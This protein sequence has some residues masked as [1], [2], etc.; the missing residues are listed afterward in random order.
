MGREEEEEKM[1]TNVVYITLITVE[2]TTPYNLLYLGR[3]Q[4]QKYLEET[5]FDALTCSSV[6]LSL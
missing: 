4:I 6:S 1:R 3:L 5:A 2:F